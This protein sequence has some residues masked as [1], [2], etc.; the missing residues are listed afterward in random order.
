M[1]SITPM[2]VDGY[3]FDFKDVVNVYV[4]DEKDS[5]SPHFHGGF[6]KA[7]DIIAEFK[8]KVFFIEVKD[9]RGEEA[10]YTVC[11]T[12]SNED[13]KQATDAVKWLKN[14]LKYKFRDTYL[15][16]YAEGG[17]SPKEIHYI[18][19]LTLT[20]GVSAIIKKQ[21]R[22]EL[23]VGKKGKR[24]T[25]ILAKSCQVVDVNGWNCSFLSEYADVSLT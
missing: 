8:N 1:S 4:F 9:Y 17:I 14:Y 10:K 5:S 3:H 24:W 22:E 25:T 2:D 13:A 7:V 21:L 6:M 11:K 18:C 19:L 16:R 12:M 23:P 15:Y 20:S